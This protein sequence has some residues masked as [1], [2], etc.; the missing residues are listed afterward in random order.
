MLIMHVWTTSFPWYRN[1]YH[2]REG[3]G[4]AF[5]GIV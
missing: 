1:S 5:G 4:A 2:G 3:R